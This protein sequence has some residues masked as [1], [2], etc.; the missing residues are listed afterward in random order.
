VSRWRKAI[1]GTLACIG[2]W[3]GAVIATQPSVD[4]PPLPIKA[5]GVSQYVTTNDYRT[6]IAGYVVSIPDGFTNDLASLPAP[7]Q[8]AIG[9]TRDHPAIRRGALCH[10]WFYRTH[11]V[12]KEKADWLLYQACLEDGMQSDKALAVYEAVRLWGFVAWDR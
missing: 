4:A 8:K 1:L 2:I 11:L 9:I 7:A 5:L 6:V 10:D 12:S 3:L